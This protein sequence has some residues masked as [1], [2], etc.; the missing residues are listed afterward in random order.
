MPDTNISD[1]VASS[2]QK[3]K[4]NAN[5]PKGYDAFLKAMKTIR[6]PT[7]VINAEDA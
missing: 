3:L 1:L 4:K 2:V 5:N 7:N 6:V